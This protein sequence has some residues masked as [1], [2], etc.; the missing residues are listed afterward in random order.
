LLKSR[1]QAK[2]HD[3]LAN[4]ASQQEKLGEI[5]AEIGQLGGLDAYQQ[6]SKLG[7]AAD[8]GGGTERVFISWLKE[9][10]VRPPQAD[11]KLKYV[12]L[13]IYAISFTENNP[14]SLKLEH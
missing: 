13:S 14:D 1:S 12:C 5:D 10:D 6:M 8:R 7:Q 3:L 11:A 2:R 4:D 9:L